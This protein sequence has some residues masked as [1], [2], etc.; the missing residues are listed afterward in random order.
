MTRVVVLDVNETLTD[1]AVLGPAFEDV[2]LDGRDVGGWFAE[3]L[4]DA[5]AL[6][7]VGECPAFADV[8][9]ALLRG[10]LEEAGA[11]HPRTG[12]EHVLDAFRALPPHPDVVPG[13]VA[14]AEAGL[15][16][17]T[18]TNGSADTARALLDGT[19]AAD[20][21]EQHL[22]VVDAGAWKPAAAA[23]R[24]AVVATGVEPGEALLAAVHPWD[25][26]GARYAGLRTAWVRRGR[27]AYPG[28]LPAPDLEVGGLDDLA[29]QLSRSR[30]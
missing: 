29:E 30:R 8:A 16:V 11:T 9:T 7:V 4:R 10:R 24:H 18:L 6:T 27:A 20:A 13:I 28:H 22:S 21:V 12:A 2:G 26:T 23:Y 3:V 25:L 14:L 5:F 1:L 17:V 19:D 15:R